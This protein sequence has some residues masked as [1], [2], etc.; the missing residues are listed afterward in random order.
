MNIDHRICLTW[1]D[2]RH[3]ADEMPDWG[4]EPVIVMTSAGYVEVD[5]DGD[6]YGY[7]RKLAHVDDSASDTHFNPHDS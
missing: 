7:G 3:C 4:E 1:N 5:M 2:L 6:V